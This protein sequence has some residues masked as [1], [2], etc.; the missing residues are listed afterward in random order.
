MNALKRIAIAAALLLNLGIQMV[1]SADKKVEI[2]GKIIAY[3]PADRALQVASHVLNKESFL[4]Q[5]TGEHRSNVIKLVYEHFGYTNLVDEILS[6]SPEIQIKARRKADC[7]ET[8]RSFLQ[9]SPKLKNDS[10]KN[11]HFEPLIFVSPP[12]EIKPADAQ[13]LR[14]YVVQKDDLYVTGI[15]R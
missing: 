4:F 5:V 6:K 10:S 9:S 1:H 7:D 12:N 2:R 15:K 14:C 11:G 13:L 8:Y 3:R